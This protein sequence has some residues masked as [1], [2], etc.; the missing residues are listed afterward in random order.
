MITCRR[1]LLW[2][3][4][5][6]T[7]VFSSIAVAQSAAGKPEVLIVDAGAPAHPFPHFWEHIFGSAPP[8]LPAWRPAS[9]CSA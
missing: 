7:L 4:L 1:S 2:L 9:V 5:S 3:V 6:T 8:N